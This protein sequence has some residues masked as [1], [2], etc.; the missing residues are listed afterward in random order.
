MTEICCRCSLASRTG[1]A[2][3]GDASRVYVCVL[4]PLVRLLESIVPTDRDLVG[5]KGQNVRNH[6]EIRMRLSRGS[7]YLKGVQYVIAR[8]LLLGDRL[9]EEGRDARPPRGQLQ[10]SAPSCASRFSPPAPALYT[11]GTS[12]VQLRG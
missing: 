10:L 12:A 6:L 8:L 9:L 11:P 2:S 4:L 5:T 7:E 3:T 1:Q